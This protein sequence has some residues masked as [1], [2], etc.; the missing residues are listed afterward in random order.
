MSKITQT[1]IAIAL[2][3]PL[4]VIGAYHV[5]V[6]PHETPRLTAGQ[7]S[8]LFVED[9]KSVTDFFTAWEP[10]ER[11]RVRTAALEEATKSENAVSFGPPAE[12]AKGSVIVFYDVNCA[13]CRATHSEMMRLVET[14][15]TV[16]F[17][18]RNVPVLGQDSVDAAIVA[19]AL[20]RQDL[21][22]QFY[23]ATMSEEDVVTGETALEIANSLGANELRLNLD[24]Q[25]PE[26]DDGLILNSQIAN[27]LGFRVPPMAFIGNTPIDISR[28]IAPLEA[29]LRSLSTQ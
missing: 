12:T 18:F 14:Y 15:S 25:D 5:L 1:T 8:Q 27:R 4:A 26:I 3:W 2:A 19:E 6:A 22:R 13:P 29:A 17:L 7:V 16:R 24:I 11:E 21:A 10:W 9:P 23:R 28:G 20:E